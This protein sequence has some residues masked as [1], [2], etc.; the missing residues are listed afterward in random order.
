MVFV[1]GIAEPS[2]GRNCGAHQC[3]G[4]TLVDVG[5][6]IR[7]SECVITTSK[8]CL[9]LRRLSLFHICVC[10]IAHGTAERAVQARL[11][12]AHDAVDEDGSGCR[13]GFLPRAKIYAGPE[14]DRTLGFRFY[15][16]KAMLGR[17]DNTAVRKY[18]HDNLGMARAEAVLNLN[19]DPLNSDDKKK[20][21]IK[22]EKSDRAVVK[23][24][25]KRQKK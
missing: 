24:G 5:T 11:V 2:A 8:T 6:I 18:S 16:V 21:R 15:Q 4:Q 9:R 10:C 14:L 19:G 25:E 22:R 1:V 20:P 7:F 23:R 3:C 13:V 17:S 12:Q